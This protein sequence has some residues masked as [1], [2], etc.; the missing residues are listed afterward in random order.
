[1]AKRSGRHD[2][3][4]RGGEIN[5]S[6]R[7]GNK[8]DATIDLR[9]I[10]ENLIVN[11]L[12]FSCLIKSFL[13][14]FLIFNFLIKFYFNVCHHRK[15]VD[16]SVSGGLCIARLQFEVGGKKIATFFLL[17]LLSIPPERKNERLFS[18]HLIG[19]SSLS[20]IRNAGARSRAPLYEKSGVY[21]AGQGAE[22]RRSLS[23]R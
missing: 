17:S 2:R 1:M 15:W 6:P 14:F 3:I 19:F 13:I 22:G 11:L 20:G 5:K 18:Y 23:A 21:V 7:Y 8:V 12:F 16:L 9:S 10:L 4:R